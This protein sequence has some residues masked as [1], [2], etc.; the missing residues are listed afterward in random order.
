MSRI[1]QLSQ[2][3]EE[4]YLLTEQES[5]EFVANLFEIIR[6]RLLSDR[7]V[8]VKGL[9]TFKLTEMNARESVN[10]NTGERITIEGR[11]KLSFTPENAVRD[12]INS[13]FAS[14]ESIDMDDNVDFTAIDQKYD[15]TTEQV[16]STEP[17]VETPAVE[18]PVVETPEVPEA[19]VA[20]IETID[21][22]A[23]METIA[24][25]PSAEVAE[26]SVEESAPSTEPVEESTPTVEP[27]VETESVAETKPEIKEEQE[28]EAKEEQ[29]PE[30]ETESE[31]AATTPEEPLPTAEPLPVAEPLSEEESEILEQTPS[32]VRAPICEELIR[33]DM[34]TNKTIINLL[35]WVLALVILML[36]CIGAYCIYNVGRGVG[37]Q[38]FEY[39]MHHNAVEND[40]ALAAEKAALGADEATNETAGAEKPKHD[41]SLVKTPKPE[42]KPDVKPEPA[43]TA[44]PAPVAKPVVT[45]PAK[46]APAP[47]AKPAPTTKPVAKPAPAA[48][49]T[50]NNMDARVRTG[51]Y[52]IV[53]TQ[54]TIT[55]RQGQ[56]LKSISKFY[57]GE[58]MECYI[59][60]YNGGKTSFQ[61]GEKV[62]IPKLELK[63]KAKK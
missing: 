46:P 54:E 6:E 22:I 38:E 5:E 30:N 58:G 60:A 24:T 9:G 11:Y 7:I 27:L 55:V 52:N 12:R 42:V 43:P 25:T 35:R 23:S 59:E 3:L 10:V 63:K 28:P 31:P 17:A 61:A 26:A 62:R 19:P 13:P 1:K 29:E 2:C 32:A 56:T 14:F 51:A 49:D 37:A 44:K 39:Y 47:A 8:K 18:V 34:N 36:L 21:A 48:S 45:P 16:P 53:G 40:D 50:Y 41:I 33:K 15:S 20:P 4:K 57:L